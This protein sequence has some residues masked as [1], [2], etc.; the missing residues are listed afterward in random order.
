MHILSDTVDS[1]LESVKTLHVQ[2]MC[3]RDSDLSAQ[4]T[5]SVL[6]NAGRG[7]CVRVKLVRRKPLRR[8]IDVCW[9]FN[10]SRLWLF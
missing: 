8:V 4:A 1:R 9:P 7:V 2:L 10:I 6:L 5:P 3:Y